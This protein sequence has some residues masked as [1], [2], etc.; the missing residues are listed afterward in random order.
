MTSLQIY[1][2]TRLDI[3]KAIFLAPSILLAV[4]SLIWIIS[5]AADEDRF[6]K[7]ALR[8]IYISLGLFFI[9]GMIPGERTLAAM[10]IIPKLER[11]EQLMK[12]PDNLLKLANDW[13]QELEPKK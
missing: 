4:G 10:I 9:G 6:E 2:I 8:Y 7:R 3:L 13:I 1:L 12:L 5:V 11:N